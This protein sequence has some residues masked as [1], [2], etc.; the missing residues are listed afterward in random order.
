MGMTAPMRKSDEET[1]APFKRT[2]SCMRAIAE[3]KSVPVTRPSS[4]TQG[5]TSTTTSPDR[6]AESAESIVAA[7]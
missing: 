5:A 7:R 1:V 3:M 6:T 4:H 2:L